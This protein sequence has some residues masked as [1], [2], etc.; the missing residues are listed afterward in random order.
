MLLHRG[1]EML[2]LNDMFIL[3]QT[4]GGKGGRDRKKEGR[5]QEG[6][7]VRKEGELLECF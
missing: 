6:T 4:S 3:S 7:G 5:K 2:H 1:K